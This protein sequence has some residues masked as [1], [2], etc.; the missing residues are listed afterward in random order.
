MRR[1]VRDPQLRDFQARVRQEVKRIGELADGLG[2]V[3][4]AI[5]DPTQIDKRRHHEHGPPIYV[6]QSKQITVRANDHMRDGGE[7]YDSSRCKAG[8]L[9]RVMTRWRVPRF[10]I[11]D[12]APTHVTSLIAE[13]VWAR[14]FAWLGY[15]LA[16]KW[17]EHRTKEPPRGLLSVPEKR[18]WN[19][20]AGEAIQDQVSVHLECQACA[21][22]REV[23]LLEL[24]P[25]TP[26]RSLRSLQLTC[27]VCGDSLLRIHR[28]DAV[29]WRWAA[30]HPRPMLSPL[31][32]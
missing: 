5:R 20:T 7:T 18:L 21:I 9:K 3:V 12:T 32:R 10:E 8:L 17:P 6:G 19:L 31:E 22:R 13:T 15:D 16:N 24:R 14:R 23:N 30:Y 2:Y 27:P 1:Y 11:L 26:L 25:E 29:R 4:Y 28:P